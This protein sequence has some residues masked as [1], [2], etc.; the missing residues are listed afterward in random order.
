MVLQANSANTFK[1]ASRGCL[2]IGVL[3]F[4]ST[5]EISS[6]QEPRMIGKFEFSKE[7]YGDTLLIDLVRLESLGAYLSRE[8]IHRLSYFDITLITGGKGAFSIDGRKTAVARGRVFPTAPGQ[9]RQWL[10]AVPP[11]GYALIFEEEF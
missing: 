3:V 4:Q 1:S 7:K 6:L 9:V 5:Q 10:C 11:R 2:M 8:P